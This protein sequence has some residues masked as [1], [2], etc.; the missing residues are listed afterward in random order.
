MND[1]NETSMPA[2]SSDP[3]EQLDRLIAV[4]RSMLFRR[5]IEAGLLRHALDSVELARMMRRSWTA[6]DEVCAVDV[7]AHHLRLLIR[8]LGGS[9]V[10]P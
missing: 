3:R 8:S 1:T 2:I 9:V 10:K 4:A 6:P 5:E 7:V